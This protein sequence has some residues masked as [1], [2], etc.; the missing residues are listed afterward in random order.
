MLKLF[1]LRVSS[2]AVLAF[3]AT[4]ICWGAIFLTAP[5]NNFVARGPDSAATNLAAGVQQQQQKQEMV[6]KLMSMGMTLD[7]ANQQAEPHE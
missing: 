2:L 4:M 3:V 6:A 7:Q 1:D 5:A